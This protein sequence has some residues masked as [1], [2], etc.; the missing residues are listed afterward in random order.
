MPVQA[1]IINLDEVDCFL[2]TLG[3]SGLIGLLSA[4]GN[5]VGECRTVP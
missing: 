2:E 5:A 3:V 4:I 1:H